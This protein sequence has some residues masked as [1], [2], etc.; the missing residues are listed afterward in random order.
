VL[1]GGRHWADLSEVDRRQI[2]DDHRLA[3]VA[4]APVNWCPGLGAV[5]ADAEVTADGRSERGNFPVFHRTMRQW[6]M[7]ITAYADRLADDLD[8][9][10]RFW[11]GGDDVS[12]AGLAVQPAAVLGRAVPDR[13]R[14]DTVIGDR[15]GGPGEVSGTIVRWMRGLTTGSPGRTGART[16]TS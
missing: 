2:I 11:R 5:L 7:R 8:G 13:L 10:Q 6:L 12:V 14:R 16:P 1:A 4:D 3:Y 15:C 9:S